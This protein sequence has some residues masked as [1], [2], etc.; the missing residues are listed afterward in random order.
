MK[1]IMIML[2]ACFAIWQ[3]AKAD[4][5]EAGLNM[6]PPGTVI[7]FQTFYD[8]LSPYGSWVSYPGHGYV[9]H[10]GLSS[11]FSPYMTNGYWV[12][13]R[14]GWFWNS[15]YRWGWAPFHYGSWLYDD[16]YGWLWVPGYVWAPAWV[17]WGYTDGYYGWAP[18]MPGVGLGSAYYGYRP[19]YTYWHFVPCDRLTDRRLYRA[20]VNR[21]Q[22][23]NYVRNTTIINNFGATRDKG[24][25]FN[26]GPEVSQVEKFTRKSIKPMNIAEQKSAGATRLQGNA[27][28]AYRPGVSRA[29][30]RPKTV[31]RYDK[32]GRIAPQPSTAP[33]KERKVQDKPE[34]I[35]GQSP[36]R[37]RTS[38]QAPKER[39]M[40][41]S[42]T[43][44]REKQQK[45]P[46]PAPR[47]GSPREQK[48]N[49][50][51]NNA[52]QPA[53]ENPKSQRMQPQAQPQPAPRPTPPPKQDKMS[54]GRNGG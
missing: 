42:T 26:T 30:A 54:G 21:T 34:K 11:G 40:N 47:P 4:P 33:A 52:P 45:L 14:E 9:W 49:D 43:P 44:A 29:E 48:L 35:Q 18:I 32:T 10:P 20:A 16:F 3:T 2:I 17:N 36:A 12:S 1:K 46:T 13:T 8:E 15:G 25:R 24:W 53:Y 38:T 5:G 41:P 19:S 39:H 51:R 37:P 6:P 31:A 50:N 7:T 27:V 28:S 22:V 23:N